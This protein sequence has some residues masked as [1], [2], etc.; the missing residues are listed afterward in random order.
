M[1]SSE[2]RARLGLAAAFAVFLLAMGVLGSKAFER[3][4]DRAN[5]ASDFTLCDVDGHVVSL[6]SLKG[7]TTVLVFWSARGPVS[8]KYCRRVIRLGNQYADD[9]RVAVLTIDP[10]LSDPDPNA[11]DEARVF[12]NVIAQRIPVLLDL[13]GKVARQYGV[14]VTPTAIVIDARGQIRYRGAFDDNEDEAAVTKT[15][16]TDALASILEDRPVPMAFTQAFGR[17]IGQPK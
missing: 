10:T 12:K 16:C 11:L 2:R 8:A 13:G 15:Y 4:R 9:E 17:P 14:Q 6:A 7:K 3:E 5:S 1:L